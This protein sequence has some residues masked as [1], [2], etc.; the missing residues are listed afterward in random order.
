M[1]FVS[2]LEAKLVHWFAPLLAISS[3]SSRMSSFWHCIEAL[4][5]KAASPPFRAMGVPR[6]AHAQ[7]LSTLR[8]RQVSTTLGKKGPGAGKK[9]LSDRSWHGRDGDSAPRPRT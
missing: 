3:V 5:G 7:S 9:L 8:V 2:V 4:K 6:A 1:V